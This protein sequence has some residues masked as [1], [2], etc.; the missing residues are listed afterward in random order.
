MVELLSS[1]VSAPLR[2]FTMSGRIS[3]IT[4][5]KLTPQQELVKPQLLLIFSALVRLHRQTAP[6]MGCQ[7]G[8]S[9]NLPKKGAMGA[10]NPMGIVVALK[11]R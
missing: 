5:H 11:E 10:V 2:L 8:G 6:P 1:G 7:A 9:I 3:Q 4:C